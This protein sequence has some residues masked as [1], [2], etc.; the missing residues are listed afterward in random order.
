MTRPG[1]SAA[2]L[3][4]RA[5]PGF[6]FALGLA[7]AWVTGVHWSDETVSVNLSREAVKNAPAYGPDMAWSRE[8]DLSLYQ[9]YGRTGYWAGSPVL[10]NEV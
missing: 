3:L 6:R 8:S 2:S 10:E 4:F 9:H 7:S 5:Q 1:P